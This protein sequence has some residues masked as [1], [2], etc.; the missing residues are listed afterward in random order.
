MTQEPG[1][2]I[3]CYLKYHCEMKIQPYANE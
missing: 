2:E 1:M 3:V